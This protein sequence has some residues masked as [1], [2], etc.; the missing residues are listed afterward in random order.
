MYRTEQEIRNEL[1]ILY[2]TAK[3]VREILKK[4]P[5]GNLRISNSHSKPEYYYKQEGES[6]GNGSYIKK[7]DMG[8]AIAI[9]Q[10]DYDRLLLVSIERR[11]ALIEEFVERYACIKPERVYDTLNP[12]RRELVSP[13]ILSDEEYVKQWLMV[14]YQGK[15]LDDGIGS[16]I[17]E[18]GERVRSKSEKIIADKLYAMGIPY[19]YEYPVI[20]SNSIRVYPDFTILKMP[21]RKE[22]YL[23]HLGLLDEETY[24][25]STMRKLNLYSENGIFLGDNLLIT[26]E[27]GRHPLN[28]KMLDGMLR[29]L[30]WRECL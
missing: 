2:K 12:Y 11:I 8:K 5:K 25:E 23:E 19:R 30:A 16:I 3:V 15:H 6:G 7:K 4:A 29:G 28:T 9:A 21:E 13:R 17:T 27:T 1:K 20:L 10:R 18:K 14:E 22:V 24:L 26:C